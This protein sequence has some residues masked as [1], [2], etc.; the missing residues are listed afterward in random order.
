VPLLRL[1][2]PLQL[3]AAAWRHGWPMLEYR[4]IDEHTH[5]TANNYIVAVGL[6]L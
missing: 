2:V 6:Q 5:H 3:A 4:H 1:P